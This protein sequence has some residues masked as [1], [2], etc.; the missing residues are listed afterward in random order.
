MLKYRW[1]TRKNFCVKY[2]FALVIY[3][4][5]YIMTY[6]VICFNTIILRHL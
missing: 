5:S 3:Y 4:P 2:N 1:K 6:N